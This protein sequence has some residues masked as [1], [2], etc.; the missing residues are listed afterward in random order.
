MPDF[1]LL[2]LEAKISSRTEFWWTLQQSVSMDVVQVPSASILSLLD[3]ELWKV[4]R[5]RGLAIAAALPEQNA[6]GCL[7]NKASSSCRGRSEV[8]LNSV[9]GMLGW[10]L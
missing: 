7:A 5:T 3:T 4:L 1:H 2:P 10:L 9:K 8:P 6:C